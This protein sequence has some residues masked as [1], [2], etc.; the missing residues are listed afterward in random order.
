MHEPIV[1]PQQQDYDRQRH[2]HLKQDG[3]RTLIEEAVDT[4]AEVLRRYDL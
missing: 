1:G 3:A 4:I 2:S